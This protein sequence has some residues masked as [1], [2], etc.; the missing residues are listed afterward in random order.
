M[1]V[2]PTSRLDIVAVVD[3]TTGG[4][5]RDGTLLEKLLFTVIPAV[6]IW[7]GWFRFLP[8]YRLWLAQ[9]D[10]PLAEALVLFFRLILGFLTL[11]FAVFLPLVWLG[12]AGIVE[13][14]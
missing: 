9:R 14:P 5:T 11:A 4:T 1:E 13:N 10:F 6:L 3:A 12:L 7:C 8:W 2:S